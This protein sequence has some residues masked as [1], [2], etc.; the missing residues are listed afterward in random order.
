MMGY[1][2]SPSL[3]GEGQG[4]GAGRVVLLSCA[5]DTVEVAGLFETARLFGRNTSH[6]EDWHVIEQAPLLTQAPHPTL[7]GVFFVKSKMRSRRG[8]SGAR[9]VWAFCALRRC[10]RIGRGKRRAER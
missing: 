3:C 9:F 4:E 2:L 6:L 7:Y 10:R 8:G 1:P 5:C